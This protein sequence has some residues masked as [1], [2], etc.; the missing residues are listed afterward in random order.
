M[1]SRIKS[2]MATTIKEAFRQYAAN[3][4]ITD[5]QEQLVSQ[6]HRGAIDSLAAQL[7]LH[8]DR[9]RVIGSWD[10]TTLTRYLSE[11]DVD[12]M[13]ILHHGENKHW[14]T[15]NGTSAALARFESIL[16]ESYP[17]TEIRVDQHCVTMTFA[18][19]RLDVV[20]AFYYTD[21]HYRIP[22][23]VQRK[24]LK[25]DPIAFAERITAINKTMDGDFVP[26]IKMVK[27]W[28]RNVGWPIKSFHL[29]C[30]M[31]GRYKSYT[32][33]YTY[34]SMLKAFFDA[35]PGYLSQPCYDPVTSERVDGYLDAG[36]S[37]KRSAVITNAK[38]AA[39]KAAEAYVDED[40]YPTVAIREWK[41]LL[42]AFFP[43]YG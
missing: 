9:S 4:N 36:F 25:T 17:E 18:E 16:E 21:G 30:L 28:N 37:G 20:P 1:R 6:R 10:R 39:A 26:L 22:D 11:G 5:R 32:R 41:D 31:H 8:P 13:A 40:K 33:S 23:T 43:A 42:G 3:L 34:D 2:I 29:E 14:E 7:T 24:W 19:F 15:P 27:G 12:V 35:L 38:E